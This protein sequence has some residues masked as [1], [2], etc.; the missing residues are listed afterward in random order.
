MSVKNVAV[1]LAAGNGKRFGE[2]T[3]KQFLK[4]GGR[5]VLEYS[6]LGFQRHP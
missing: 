4:V 1:I 2:D 5:V 3:P 6:M